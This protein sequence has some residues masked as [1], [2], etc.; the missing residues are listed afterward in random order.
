M[1]MEN[2]LPRS[3]PEAEGVSSKGI[4]AF[5]EAVTESVHD[6]H[7]FML[8]RH[9]RVVA[10]GW[11]SPY[12]PDLPHMLFSLSKSFTST[13]IGLVVAEG[14]LS[15]DDSIVSL[16]PEDCPKNVSEPL[17][18]L[19]VRHLLTMTSGHDPETFGLM[20]SQ[21]EGHWVKGFFNRPMIH[22]PGTHFAYD[23][24]AAYMLSAVVQ[25]VTGMTM[26]D[27]LQQ[28][29]FKSLGINN[30]TWTACPRGINIGFAGLSLTTEEVA[31][32]GQLHLQK[33]VW[34]GQQLLPVGWVEEATKRQVSNGNNPNVDEEQGYG[35]L[36]WRI[37]HGAYRGDGAFGQICEV[38][39]KQ[40]AVLAIT[41]GKPGMEII[42]DLVWEHVLPA[43]ST[44]ALPEDTLAEQALNTK[45]TNLSIATVHGQS[46]SPVARQ[47]SKQIFD[48]NY[49]GEERLWF[50]FGNGRFGAT[51]RSISFDFG[52][53]GCACTIGDDRDVHEVVSGNGYWRRGVTT[54]SSQ[55]GKSEQP[56]AASGAWTADDTYEMQWCFVE[57]A[58]RATLT[59]H[60]VEDTITI[61]WEENATFADQ[62][63]P[64]LRG[65]VMPNKASTRRGE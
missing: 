43:M 56:V 40:D 3:S 16:L 41:A 63:H 14:R 37:R 36:F 15:L 49:Q 50:D 8:L 59:C 35:Y 47:V 34:Q 39:P 2:I 65:Q 57:T 62:K 23:N 17:A 61:D 22:R 13:A 25:Q 51:F 11:W 38:W 27:Y 30:A 48:L 4:L 1:T 20:V 26:L 29:L 45:L 54:V 18:A 60:F 44:Q 42:Q 19:R 58:F 31:R 6:L 55:D 9:G 10:E 33:G 12:A 5:L 32:F 24:C 53:D 21:P 46:D 64:Q 28:H 52:P 7:S